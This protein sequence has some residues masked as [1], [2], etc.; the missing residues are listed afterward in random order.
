VYQRYNRV[1]PVRGSPNVRVYDYRPSWGFIPFWWYPP[2]YTP[3]GVLV[4]PGGT[5]PL[6]ILLTLTGVVLLI[7]VVV[8]LLRRR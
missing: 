2:I 8:A 6:G 4:S 1:Q 7:V 5:N 3:T